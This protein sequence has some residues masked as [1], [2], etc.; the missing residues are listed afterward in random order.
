MEYLS[1]DMFSAKTSDEL[2][3]STPNLLAISTQNSLPSFVPNSQQQLFN[4]PI[5]LQSDFNIIV[6]QAINNLLAINPS[7]L[8]QQL[9]ALSTTQEQVE[10]IEL[11][12]EELE[13]DTQ[14]DLPEELVLS[15]EDVDN[16]GNEGTFGDHLVGHAKCEINKMTL[17]ND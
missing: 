8:L 9:S 12:D 15:D 17:G 10:A 6:Q 16:E 11:Y 5:N 14:N 3:D 7:N 2:A 4:S 13:E 1:S